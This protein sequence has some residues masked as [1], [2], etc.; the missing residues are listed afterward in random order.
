MALTFDCSIIAVYRSN[1]CSLSNCKSRAQLSKSIYFDQLYI[2]YLLM[3][4]F[5]FLNYNVR[6]YLMLKYQITFM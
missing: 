4:L 5:R 6:F 1:D 2:L 3:H